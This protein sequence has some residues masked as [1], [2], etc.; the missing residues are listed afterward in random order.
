M[1]GGRNSTWA[2]PV[3]QWPTSWKV[4]KLALEYL[5]PDGCAVPQLGEW[6]EQHHQQS[7]WY[8][9]SDH[10][11]LYHHS[12]CTWEQHSAHSRARLRFKTLANACDRP[13]SATH[14]DKAKTRPRFV[15]IMDKC[16][17]P[18]CT[19]INPP[20]LVL[21]TSN[22]GTCIDALPRHVQRLVRDCTIPGR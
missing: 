14:V 3:Q 7:E 1:E 5:A 10:S 12:N 18:Q 16:K 9:A 13:A 4:W 15:E 21:Y 2:W 19:V 17:I 20:P 8:L 22:S 11:I 6:L